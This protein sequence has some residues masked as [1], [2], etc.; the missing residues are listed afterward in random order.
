MNKIN[1]KKVLTIYTTELKTKLRT[2]LTWCGAITA[3]ILLYMLLFPVV[4]DLAMDKMSAMP[5]GLLAMFGMEG[6]MDM[7]NYNLYFAMIY[8]LVVT[9]LC[10]YAI[11]LGA[12]TFHNEETSGTI[13]FL[14]ANNISRLDIY[15]A[16]VAVV[17]TRLLAISLCALIAS[18]ISGAIV[19][20]D[21]INANAIF[22]GY[23]VSLV[24]ILFFA[25][26]GFLIAS[27]VKK[28]KNTTGIAVGGMLF[29]YI[30][31]YLG[32]LGG[33]KL[34]FIKWLSPIHSL[35]VNDVIMSTWGIGV[36]KYPIVAFIIFISLTIALSVGSWFIYNKKDLQ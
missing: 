12:S 31:G 15:I 13:E 7:T 35:S 25:S 36:G 9:V 28:N 24:A 33:D 22:M 19:A 26:A 32:E 2:I 34:Q 11:A 29:T 10:G 8:Q 16:K 23:L 21:T 6:M 1:I 14:Y 20:S 3:I 18:L 5:E 30:M 4:K 17:F 27:L